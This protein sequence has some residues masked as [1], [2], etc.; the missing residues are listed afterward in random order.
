MFLDAILDDDNN[1]TKTEEDTM[2]SK[3]SRDNDNKQKEEVELRGIVIF[4]H[5]PSLCVHLS[6]LYI[7]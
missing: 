3:V 5:S 6:S 1:N 4:V 2:S 7:Y